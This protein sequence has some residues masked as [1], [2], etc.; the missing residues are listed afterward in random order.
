MQVSVN[1]KVAA[2]ALERFTV[3]AVNVRSHTG[4]RDLLLTTYYL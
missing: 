2:M 3:Y 4:G 1:G